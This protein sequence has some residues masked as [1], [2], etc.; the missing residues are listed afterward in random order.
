[1]KKIIA[2]LFIKHPII[3]AFAVIGLIILAI[4][5]FIWLASFI[6]TEITA[7]V[8][9]KLYEKYDLKLSF[10]NKCNYEKNNLDGVCK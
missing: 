6:I 5:L 4:M 8:Y 1:M 9:I 7:R 2:L 10:I 3:M